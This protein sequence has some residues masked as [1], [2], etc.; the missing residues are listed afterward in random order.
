MDSYY[1]NLAVYDLEDFLK[2]TNEPYYD[3]E[4][5]YGRPEKGHGW[6]PATQEEMT[7]WM[8][9]HVSK[10][11]PPGVDTASWKY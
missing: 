5:R 9:D 11:A 10:H 1:L 6:Q 7:R 4:I 8:A 2:S 3:G